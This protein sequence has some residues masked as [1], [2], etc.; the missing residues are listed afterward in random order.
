M[1][2][3]QCGTDNDIDAR[4]CKKCGSG[5][6]G[7]TIQ[8][9]S[10]Q[11]AKSG[12]FYR[13]CLAT[14]AIW[15]SFLLGSFLGMGISMVSHGVTDPAVFGL[16]FGMGFVLFAGLWFIGTVVLLLLALA[17]RPS[18]PVSG[19]VQLRWQRPRLAILALFWPMV[20]ASRP[21]SPS[22]PV[23]SPSSPPSR[24]WK[25]GRHRRPMAD[26]GR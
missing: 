12:G 11:K 19:H 9:D 7:K 16:G 20:R 1:K 10:G 13:F 4:F 17:T 6:A 26:Q 8:P 5:L 24:G 25:W 2:C 14:A 15:T 21:P 22:T 18:P 3:R 23:T